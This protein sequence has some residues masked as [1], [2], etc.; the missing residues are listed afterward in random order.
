MHHSTV[1]PAEEITSCSS[2]SPTEPTRLSGPRAR[3]NSARSTASTASS[4]QRSPS[5]HTPLRR[6][7]AP[8]D[9]HGASGAASRNPRRT[10]DQRNPLLAQAGPSSTHAAAVR[11]KE[12]DRCPAGGLAAGQPGGC[13]QCADLALVHRPHRPGQRPAQVTPSLNKAGS[14]R[15]TT[16]GRCGREGHPSPYLGL[17][18]T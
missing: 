18:T 13:Y 5:Y 4:R 1:T 12:R 9:A 15:V 2:S 11:D 6:P 7:G 14:G 16:A 10:R 8:R 3:R 17:A